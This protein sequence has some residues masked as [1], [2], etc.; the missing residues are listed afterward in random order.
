M[1][2]K[3]IMTVPQVGLVG[4]NPYPIYI[5]TDDTDAEV[6]VTGYLN[7][8]YNLGYRF[9]NFQMALVYTTDKK[10]QWY[11]VSVASQAPNADKSLVRVSGG[12]GS[13]SGT[14]NRI[15]VTG[16]TDAII[17]IAATYVGQTSINTLG[18]V[19]TGT[20]SATPVGVV[21]GGLGLN[22]VAQGDLLYGSAANTYSLLT[23]NA[24]A[25]RYLSNTGTNNN[26][27]WAQ[28]DLSNGVTGNLPVTNLNSGSGASASTFWRG[29]GTWASAGGG[30]LTWNV[31]AGT[32]ENMVANNGYIPN[33]AGLV[34][35]TMPATASVGDVF[36]V[37]GL[38]SGGWLLQMNTGQIANF[39]SSPTTSAGSLASTNRYDAV[40]LICVVANT[41]FVAGSSIGNLTVA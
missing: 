12:I 5:L 41:T 36:R 28:V 33:N 14:A 32:S 37:A 16:T 25:T 39:G 29:D 8:S 10:V 24:T 27:A 1:P 30:G 21:Y 6:Q 7:E 11:Q 38:G 19:T 26:P 3:Q 31:V 20:W 4:V 2:I 22:A 35:L 9:S 40:E 17:D 34:T 13:V 15:T 23:K 18:V